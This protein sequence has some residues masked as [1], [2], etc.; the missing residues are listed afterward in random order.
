MNSYRSIWSSIRVILDIC[1]SSMNLKIDKLIHT[2]QQQ[3]SDFEAQ[4]QAK[5][6][7]MSSLKNHLSTFNSQL[8]SYTMPS[9]PLPHPTYQPHSSIWQ[10]NAPQPLRMNNTVVD[11]LNQSIF[12]QVQTSQE[13]FFNN[14]KTWDHTNPKDFESWLEEIDRLSDVRR[15]N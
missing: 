14:T 1:P 11:I 9:P 2:H 13:Q 4:I 8:L 7:E 10:N 3:V 15:K 5:H 12:Q 6:N